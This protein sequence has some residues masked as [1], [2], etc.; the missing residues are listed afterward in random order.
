MDGH[1]REARQRRRQ[2]AEDPR[3]QD[4]ERRHGKAVDLVEEVMI[5]TVAQCR[6]ALLDLAE[7]DEPAARRV[8][9]A[10][11]RHFDAKGMAVQAPV[12]MPFRRRRQEMRGIETEFL[13]DFDAHGMPMNLWVWRLRRQRGCARQY[14]T[15]RAVL[16]CRS[17]PSIGCRKKWSK[18]KSSKRRGSMPS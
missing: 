17:G 16:C 4:L 8:G 12:G 6:D 10:G 3:R 14:S 1:A 15:A 18:A 9:R 7:I 11:E 2:R 5:E 13:G